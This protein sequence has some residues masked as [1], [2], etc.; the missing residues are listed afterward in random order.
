MAKMMQLVTDAYL[1][2]AMTYRS[3][4]SITPKMV[5]RSLDTKLDKDLTALRT[6]GACKQDVDRAVIENISLRLFFRWAHNPAPLHCDEVYEIAGAVLGRAR[7]VDDRKIIGGR[8][9]ILD[10]LLRFIGSAQ[11]GVSTVHSLLKNYREA[12]NLSQ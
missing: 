2:L 9:Q 3:L 6:S 1:T 5:Q 12:L 11:G 8:Y 7:M 4:D 10:D